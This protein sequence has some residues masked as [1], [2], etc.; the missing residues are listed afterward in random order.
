MTQP[1][2]PQQDG[3]FGFWRPQTSNNEYNELRYIIQSL[4]SRINV[5][6]LVR[7]AAV[8]VEGRVAPVGTVDIVPL[9]NMVDG[10][11][12]SWEHTTIYN[13][14]YFR[15][16]GSNSAI[17]CDPQVGDVGFAV[18]CDSDISSVIAT[19]KAAPPNSARKFSYS[20]A[21]YFGGWGA[22]VLPQN[23]IVVDGVGVD[24]VAPRIN[25]TGNVS[26]STGATG[27]FTSMLGQTITVQNGII[28]GID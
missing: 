26:V 5:A 16:Q 3:V 15:A 8:H 18:F 21:L 9:V 7:V 24:I 2:L 1:A 25:L 13:V 20:D 12:A 27:T 19:S 17:I 14:P 28:T 22:T 6:T 4:M 10:S 23:Y 11:G